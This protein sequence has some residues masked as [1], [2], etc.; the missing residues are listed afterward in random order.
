L[1]PAAEKADIGPAPVDML[2]RRALG[3]RLTFYTDRR[4]IGDHQRTR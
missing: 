3:V 4:V 2:T 1:L